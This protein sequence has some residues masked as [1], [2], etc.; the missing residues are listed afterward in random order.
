MSD[1]DVNT[2]T[3][4]LLNG[5]AIVVIFLFLV[6]LVLSIGRWL[7]LWSF[8]AG[9]QAAKAAGCICD[10]SRGSEKYAVA[11]KRLSDLLSKI[12]Y[13]DT[14]GAYDPL[15]EDLS[16]VHAREIV[17]SA[18]GILA[19]LGGGDFGAGR[20][21]LLKQVAA[22]LYLGMRRGLSEHLRDTL[23]D[24]LYESELTGEAEANEVQL[25][26]QDYK[27]KATPDFSTI[28]AEGYYKV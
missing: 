24:R 15:D 11:R 6:A 5:F 25:A 27:S 20:A 22:H 2:I 7:G 13:R 21:E 17:R 10:K 26:L 14:E 16:H 9:T 1:Q 23:E 12:D 18:E 8:G 19:D 28:G 4:V 3:T